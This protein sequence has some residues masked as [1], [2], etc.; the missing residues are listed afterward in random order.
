M[1]TE[2]PLRVKTG[3]V[4]CEYMSSAVSPRTDIGRDATLRGSKVGNFVEPSPCCGS[5]VMEKLR[6]MVHLAYIK[7][8]KD[9]YLTVVGLAS[10]F[11]VFIETKC[12]QS[13]FA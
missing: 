6:A 8:T 12:C 9:D 13:E 4:Q 10:L 2:C 7:L 11:V 5:D 1:P 3:K